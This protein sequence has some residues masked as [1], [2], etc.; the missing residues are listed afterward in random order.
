MFSKCKLCGIDTFKN[1]ICW[2]CELRQSGLEVVYVTTNDDDKIIWW[3]SFA[4]D[5]CDS[6]VEV[7]DFISAVNI[8]Y[9]RE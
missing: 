2:T 7:D 3:Q 4:S 6:P 5:L 9:G 1:K 8:Q